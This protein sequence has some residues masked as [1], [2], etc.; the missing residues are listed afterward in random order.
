MGTCNTLKNAISKTA[1][2]NILNTANFPLASECDDLK[3]NAYNAY[4]TGS[5][6]SSAGKT[7]ILFPD[8][9]I[10]LLLKLFVSLSKHGIWTLVNRNDY[11]IQ[12]T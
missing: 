8:N 7:Y 1:I 10:V 11:F 9:P 12:I 2:T 5:D 3:D 4:F 6:T